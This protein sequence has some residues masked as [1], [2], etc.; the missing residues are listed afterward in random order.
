MIT[1][2]EAEPLF[3]GALTARVKELYP[4]ARI[5]QFSGGPISRPGLVAARIRRLTA[6]P[7]Q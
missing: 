3:E 4:E 2:S 1:H 5:E 7:D 6:G